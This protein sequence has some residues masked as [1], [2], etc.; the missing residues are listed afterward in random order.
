MF[1]RKAKTRTL[2]CIDAQDTHTTLDKADR[3]LRVWIW[4]NSFAEILRRTKFSIENTRIR[5]GKI[6]RQNIFNVRN[7]CTSVGPTN[8]CAIN[9]RALG[10]STWQVTAGTHLERCRLTDSSHMDYPRLQ[11]QM[12]S[13]SVGY[14]TG[15]A[16]F[17][18]LR[19]EIRENWVEAKVTGIKGASLSSLK[20]CILL[21]RR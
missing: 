6:F 12:I 7:R 1:S 4:I 5:L 19:Y 3:R 11:P 16:A 18:S 14:I 2:H 13:V 9:D 10:S 21:K 8:F 17:F 20:N 15:L